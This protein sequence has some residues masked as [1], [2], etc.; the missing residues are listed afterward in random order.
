VQVDFRFFPG[1]PK[2]ETSGLTHVGCGEGL[3]DLQKREK[4]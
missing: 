1:G 4:F 3:Q 2:G